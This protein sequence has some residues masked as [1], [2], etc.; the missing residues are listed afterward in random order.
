MRTSAKVA[1]IAGIV[2]VVCMALVAVIG[3]VVVKFTDVRIPFV[4]DTCRVYGDSR[5]VTLKPTQ[6]THAATIAAVGI[7]AGVGSQGVAVALATA[8]QE[9]KLQNIS[10]GDR[11]SLGLFQQ[12]PSQGWGTAEQVRDPNYAS[13]KFFAKLKR[14]RGWKQMRVTEAAQAVQLSAHPEAYEKWADDARALAAAFSGQETRAVTCELREGTE[15]SGDAAVKGLQAAFNRDYGKHT[16]RST[17]KPSKPELVLQLSANS[18]TGWQAA[19]WFVAKSRDY[20]IS[21][22][23]YDGAAWSASAGKWEAS[24]KTVDRHLTVRVKT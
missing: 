10:H 2:V 19:H 7:N 21:D 17:G 22:V 24:K 12:R 6:L 20:G 16:L 3:Y 1:T 14:I 18:Q 4:S 11:D 9:S 15:I 23:A 13:G 5:V 8:L